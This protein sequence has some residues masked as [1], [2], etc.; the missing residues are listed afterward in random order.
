[1][2]ALGAH[3]MQ[4]GRPRGEVVYELDC[5]FKR[6]EFEIQSLYYIH[7]HTNTIGKSINTL[8]LP[9]IS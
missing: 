2:C 1:M 3:Y 4:E 8:I 5:S 6:V 9:G 7:F